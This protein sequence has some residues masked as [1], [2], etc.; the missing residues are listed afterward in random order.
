ME[1]TEKIFRYEL[2]PGD[3]SQSPNSILC[4]PLPGD[5]FLQSIYPADIFDIFLFFLPTALDK[6]LHSW[7][8]YIV[9][10]NT[11]EHIYHENK[12]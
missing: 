4:S 1:L 7:Y 6:H 9:L 8:N 11:T 2:P 12:F 5:F 10:N 3:Y